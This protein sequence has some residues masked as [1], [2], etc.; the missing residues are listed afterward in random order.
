MSRF[1]STNLSVFSGE[2]LSPKEKTTKRRS[3]PR[4]SL[5]KNLDF[6]TESLARIGGEVCKLRMEVDSLTE[7]NKKLLENQTQLLQVISE[8]GVI[9]LE[10]FNLACDISDELH[11]SFC[12]SLRL[13]KQ[14]H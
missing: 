13:Q 10:E 11:H 6:F 8:K 12:E 14:P 2:N 3:S 9:D 7:Q 5:L 4:N 1:E